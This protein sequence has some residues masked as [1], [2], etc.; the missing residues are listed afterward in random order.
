MLVIDV[1]LAFGNVASENNGFYKFEILI[2]IQIR[3]NLIFSIF[4]LV[5]FLGPTPFLIGD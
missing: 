4:I 5:T 3:K 1:D 2:S